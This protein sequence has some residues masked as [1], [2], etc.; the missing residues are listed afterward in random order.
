VIATNHRFTEPDERLAVRTF[1]DRYAPAPTELV[2]VPVLA[3]GQAQSNEEVN[4]ILAYRAETV[5]DADGGSVT[6]RNAHPT[7]LW[8]WLRQLL[9]KEP[10]YIA[11]MVGIP[12]LASLRHLS[13]PRPSIKSSE[14]IA[15]YQRQNPST[16]KA[17]QEALA[18][19]QRLI[20][21]AG[22][23]KT[24]EDLTTGVLLSF[25]QSIE[26][27]TTLKSAGTRR[28][29]FGRIKSIIGF[30][31]KVGMDAVQI[32]ACLDRC[33]VS[34]TADPPPAPRPTPIG[35]EHFHALLDAGGNAWRP[36]LLLGLN[37]CLHLD[38]VCD[39]AWDDF[40]LEQATYSAG[41]LRRLT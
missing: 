35:R 19:L 5:V 27:S 7:A 11:K 32:R 39:L 1:R 33:K 10:E 8:G 4:Q 41:G 14:V 25:R 16:P 31:L 15:P 18:P 6:V 22:G 38:E 37:L 28:G 30:G 23:A 9:L 24:L 21:H 29:Y 12:E 40:N 13:L 17:K 34:W 3:P 36:W 2:Q 20:D 26:T